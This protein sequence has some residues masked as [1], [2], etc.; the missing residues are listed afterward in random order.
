MK[1]ESPLFFSTT[2]RLLFIA[3]VITSYFVAPLFAA[4]SGGGSATKSELP[5]QEV[6]PREHRLAHEHRNGAALCIP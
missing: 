1:H 5:G 4:A 6:I 3:I 2:G